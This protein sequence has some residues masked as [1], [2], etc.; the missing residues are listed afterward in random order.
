MSFDFD[1]PLQLR[2][3]HCQKWDNLSVMADTGIPD[4]PTDVI[5]MW[6]ADMDF[7]AAPPVVDALQEEASRGYFG[8]F[9]VPGPVA[10]AAAAWVDRKH[11]WTVD[12]AHMRFTVG[13]IGGLKIAIEAFTEPGDGV[14]VFSPVYHAFFRV[15]SALD[16]QIVESHLPVEDGRH[17]MDLE[18][19]GNAL[20]G[21][22]KAVILCSPH[23]PGG[24]IWTPE[25]L[26]DLAA[27]C[28]RH[29]LLLI[30]D[31]I[32][33]D[34]TFPD[35]VFTPTGLAA[36]DAMPRLITLTA[37]SKGFNLA[38]GETG[39]AII[40]DDALRER[41]DLAVPR[42]GAGVTRFGMVL[43]KA[44][45]THG[46]AWSAAVRSYIAGNFDLWHERIGAIPG[47][48]STKMA[49]TYLSWVDFSDTGMSAHE[50]RQRIASDARIA[51]SPGSQ[52]RGDCATHGR[53]NLA[54][55]RPL[56]LEAIE[57]MEHAFADLQ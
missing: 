47:V 55:P 34:L 5:S 56:L 22:E 27:F 40:P 8:Y 54:M 48:R 16:R 51:A 29:D 19:L 52:F 14:I 25:E 46:D 50:I 43:T 12:P 15:L 57:R 18:A 1:T 42:Y 33:M 49:A 20:T 41:F 17:H 32:H 24:R 6:V 11:A 7:K 36:P 37:A 2:G 23:N 30:S 35:T 31:E 3:S 4:D 45:F 26:R 10:E 28:A 21:N 13:V 53:F 39:I 9:G 44:A 38:G